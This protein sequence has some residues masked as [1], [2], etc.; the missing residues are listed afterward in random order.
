MSRTKS[1][2]D[3]RES[4]PIRVWIDLG[5]IIVL[6]PLLLTVFENAQNSDQWWL[7][8]TGRYICENG[9]PH[10]NPFSIY[11]GQHIVIQQWLSSMI[12]Y[13]FYSIFGFIGLGIITVI[14]TVVL[15]LTAIWVAHITLG[16]HYQASYPFIVVLIISCSSYLSIRPQV[17]SMI[18]FLVIIGLLEEYRRGASWKKTLFFVPLVVAVHVNLHASM[19]PLDFVIILFYFL[20]TQENMLLKRDSKKS[21]IGFLSSHLFLASYPMIPMMIT[22]LMMM[23]ASLC[24]PY[25]IHGALYLFESYGSASYGNYISEMG[26]LA[27]TTSYYGL[28]LIATVIMGSIVLGSN[29]RRIDLPLSGLFILTCFISFTH[30]R[31]VWLA[32]MFSYPLIL[33]SVSCHIKNK[34]FS[35]PLLHG[36]ETNPVT[37]SLA[38]IV[39]FMLVLMAPPAVSKLNVSPS[40]SAT[41]P[42]RAVDYINHDVDSS[43]QELQRNQVRVFTHFNAGGYLE[44]SGYRVSMDARPELW[45]SRISFSGKNRYVEYVDMSKGDITNSDF[46]RDKRFDYMIV[47]VNTSLYDYVR[48]DNEYYE[49]MNGNGYA[50][51]KHV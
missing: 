1:L 40:D 34:S 21:V 25:G 4:S 35:Y 28:T 15:V 19:M 14:F 7:L 37:A 12:D 50:L 33:N 31:N 49:A 32:G 51:F 41:T 10:V 30:V 6:A 20:S 36:F 29:G 47:N 2:A 43:G 23:I 13:A 5:L 8:A 45:D 3:C 17:I 38:T 48:L 46:M 27:P 24:N 18:A 26:A 16:I 42:I 9:I 22:M 39:I 44:W 11:D